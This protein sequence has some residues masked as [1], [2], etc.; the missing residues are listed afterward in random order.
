M[1]ADLINKRI[2]LRFLFNKGFVAERDAGELGSFLRNNYSFPACS[3]QAERG[4]FD[5]HPAADPWK[6]A[7]DALRADADVPLPS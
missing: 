4:N 3:G 2:Q 1:Q 5:N 6:A 7:V